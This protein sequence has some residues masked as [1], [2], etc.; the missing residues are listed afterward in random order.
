MLELSA[1]VP[2]GK[3]IGDL[4]HLESAFERDGEVELASKEQK[5]VC[6]GI[7]FSN[8]LNLIVEIQ[9]R[10]DLFRQCF[11]CFNHPA[12]FSRGKI[13]HPSEEQSEKRENYKLRGKRF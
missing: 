9:N 13:A 10:F 2:F 12:A 3:E 7:F 6:V 1:R 4:L 11:Q 5:P 8:C